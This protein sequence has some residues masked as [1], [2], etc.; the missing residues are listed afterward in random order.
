[1]T[2]EPF[3]WNVVAVGYWNLA[4]LTPK[5]IATRLYKL[6]EETP[7]TVEVPIDGLAPHRVRHEGIIIRAEHGRL[8]IATE[9]PTLTDL[10][11]A[12]EIAIT[13]I[14]WLSETPLTAVGINLKFKLDE[15][16]EMLINAT[17]TA[18]D[19]LLSDDGFE[20]KIKKSNRS[21]VHGLGLVNLDIQQ[22]E[23]AE[24]SI[25]FNFHRQS[26]LVSELLEWLKIPCDDIKS[27]C[28][29]IL[30]NLTGNGFREEWQ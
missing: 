27:I 4:I 18:L 8:V 6:E 20:I 3:D 10:D 16:P 15:P 25:E 11:R 17:E 13:A 7:I 19:K 14:N 24:T 23:N 30:Y 29:T 12:R 9:N 22:N 2:M 28:S 1:M 26:F 5:G 21:F